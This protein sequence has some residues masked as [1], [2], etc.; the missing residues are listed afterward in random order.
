MKLRTI[1][2]LNLENKSVL[3]RIDLNSH[4]Q[5]GKIVESDRIKIHSDTIKI[6]LKKKAKVVILAHQGDKGKRKSLEQHY[7]I[8]KKYLGRQIKFV[9]DILGKRAIK[10]IRNLNHG[11]ALLLENIRFLEEEFKPEKNNLIVRNLSIW[12]DYYVNDAFSICHRNQTSIVGFSK[13][14]K[15][16]AGPVLIQ[17]LKNIDK[18]KSKLKDSLFILGGK[19]S[20]DLMPLLKNK[21]L[22]TGKLSLLVLM[23]NGYKLGK[24][25]KL[26]KEEKYIVSKIKRNLK[27]IKGPIDLVIS[28]E[29]KR[30][31]INIEDLP[32]NHNIWDIGKE[33][34]REYKKEIKKAKS[35]FF[36][37]SPGFFQQKG[38]EN[39]TKE[40][41]KAI[42][43][44]R[45]FSVVAGGQSSDA[46]NEFKINRKKFN[47]ISL[48][49]GALVKYLAGEKL[50]GLEALR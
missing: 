36:K 50:V 9:D 12:F 19:K 49:G 14:L 39:G 13:V 5:D 40:I 42:A 21:V 25:D 43:K 17:E 37:G 27:H 23:A 22:S 16:A 2:Q 33:T 29:G 26:M 32:T 44:S 35:I 15:S 1:N 6:L 31:E 20:K 18:I 30:K 4:F 38:F 10:A 3:L 46:I 48:S 7:R 8:M 11:E 28:V 24:E 47:Y 41:L 45:A 34:I